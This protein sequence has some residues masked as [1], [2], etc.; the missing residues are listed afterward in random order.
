MA[1]KKKHSEAPVIIINDVTY[2]SPDDMADDVRRIWDENEGQMRERGLDWRRQGRIEIEWT[3]EGKRTTN[4]IKITRHAGAVK[5]TSWSLQGVI[6]LCFSILWA[7]LSLYAFAWNVPPLVFVYDSLTLK[8]VFV[9]LLGPWVCLFFIAYV[10]KKQGAGNVDWNGSDN[11]NS[12][13]PRWMLYVAIPFTSAIMLWMTFQAAYGGVAKIFHYLERDHGEV[14][15]TV[16][17]KSAFGS[18]NAH[19]A[20]RLR[21][22]GFR[23]IGDELCVDR[24]LFDRVRVGDKIKLT[25]LVS[26]H[27]M[28]PETIEP[29]S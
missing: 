25:G 15:V 29:I 5:S 13:T 14:V 3:R 20:P 9:I 24:A 6:F 16:R 28:E 18:K 10:R 11:P 27:A 26:R 2:A 21:F 17:E 7:A 8:A 4:S 1:A 19:C 22:D 12:R 23:D